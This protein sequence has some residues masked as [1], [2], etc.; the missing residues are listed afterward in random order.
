MKRP[1]KQ[2]G[3]FRNNFTDYWD[4]QGIPIPGNTINDSQTLI[5]NEIA[6]V[7]L[8]NGNSDLQKPAMA[9]E[10]GGDNSY[11]GMVLYDGLLWLSYYSSHE[12][13][14]SVYQAKVKIK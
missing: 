5:G 4:G 1:Q 2:S 6:R 9:Q 8:W 14:T 10:S 7:V 12:G 13:K 3:I 11:A